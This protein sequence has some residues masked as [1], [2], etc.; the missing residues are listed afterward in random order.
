MR[1]TIFS[2]YGLLR[3]LGF[4]AESTFESECVFECEHVTV[5]W[6]DS[7]CSEMARETFGYENVHRL[8]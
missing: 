6:G 5:V 8:H 1:T 2:M 3:R 7:D 4:E